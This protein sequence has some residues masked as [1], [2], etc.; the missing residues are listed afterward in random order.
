L[1]KNGDKYKKKGFVFYFSENKKKSKR[2]G[3]G[4]HKVTLASSNV[5]QP[6]SSGFLPLGHNFIFR[7]ERGSGRTGLKNG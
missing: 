2:G 1:K 3:C 7:G 4:Q 6:I 5:P